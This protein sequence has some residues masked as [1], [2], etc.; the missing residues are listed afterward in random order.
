MIKTNVSIEYREVDRKVGLLGDAILTTGRKM[1][2]MKRAG[3]AKMYHEIM[4]GLIVR[5]Q[6]LRTQ[7]ATY[8]TLSTQLA[9]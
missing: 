5:L 1:S 3:Y 8:E 7:R 2:G 9:N 4:D 6:E